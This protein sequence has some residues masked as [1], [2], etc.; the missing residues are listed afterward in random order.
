MRAIQRGAGERNRSGFSLIEL[1][2]VMGILSLLFA[3]LLPAVQA[4][5]EAARRARCTNNLHQVGLALNA[6]VSD[7]GGFPPVVTGKWVDWSP[8]TGGPDLYGGHYSIFSRMLP[9]LDQVGLYHSLNFETGTWRNNGLSKGRQALN[10]ANRTV[11]ETTLDFLLCPSDGGPF[12]DAGNN[13]RGNVGVGPM[14]SPSAEYPDSGN[15]IFPGSRLVSARTGW[16]IDGLSHTAAFSERLRGSSA[17]SGVKSTEAARLV[18]E[19]D[20]YSLNV[21]T[22]TADDLLLGCRIAARPTNPYGG[23]TC[24]GQ[25]WF[26][27]DQGD[28]LYNHA[29]VP[30]GRV[31]DCTHIG[32]VI[33]GGMVTAQS[34]FW[35]GE[36]GNGRRLGPLHIREHR[37]SRLRGFG[38]RNGGELVD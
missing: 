22:R 23:Y 25:S 12:Q 26:W 38:T 18:P 27:S 36:R 10:R 16:V 21:F 35:R 7:F 30:N 2:V 14:F 24:A 4:A 29:E 33:F 9:Q 17:S 32:R 1:L 37:P 28:T 34:A 11:W 3:L 31:P 15:G 5:R 8:V 13:Y 6:Y 20:L 19:R